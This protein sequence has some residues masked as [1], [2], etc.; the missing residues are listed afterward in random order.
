MSPTEI[1]TESEPPSSSTSTYRTAWL[2]VLCVVGLDYMSTLGYMPSIA[3]D[4]AGRLAPLVMGFVGLM[5]ICGALPLYWYIAGRSP[6]GQGF[7]ALL[8]KHISGWLGKLLILVV[9]S[10]AA[11]DFI[12]TRT[13][14][15]ADAAEHVIHSPHPE[16]NQTLKDFSA[17][18]DANKHHL[19]D[20]LEHSVARWDGP[21]LSATLVLLFVGMVVGIIFRKGIRRRFIQ[22]AVAVVG[23]YLLLNIIVIGA[24]LWFLY[25]HPERVADWWHNVISGNWDARAVQSGGPVSAAPLAATCVQLFPKVILGLSGFEMVMLLMP[26]V[27]GRPNDD[28]ERPA[29]RIRNTR[30][31]LLAAGI[32][33]PLYLVAASFVTTLL[34]PPEAF[35]TSGQAANRALAYLAHG[36]V[37]VG[38]PSG[39]TVSPLFGLA[40]GTIYDVGTIAILCLAGVGVSLC[41]LSYVPPTLHRLGMEL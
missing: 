36:G 25:D 22:I 26:L 7:T 15:T 39:E 16:W 14:S 3:Y 34:I 38:L 18:F 30:K 4:S 29:G 31:L 40:F 6:H 13:F 11:A 10:F 33:M 2:W 35:R 37:V 5:T 21:R 41:L 24:G 27:K 9:L 1:P 28:P 20:W 17:R 12:F 19:P 32:T 8:E 23:F